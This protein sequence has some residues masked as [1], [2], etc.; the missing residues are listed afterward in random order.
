MA[1]SVGS[2]IFF[3]FQWKIDEIAI[4]RRIKREFDDGTS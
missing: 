3:I 4:Y 1:T 2:I